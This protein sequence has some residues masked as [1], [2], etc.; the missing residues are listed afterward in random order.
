MN[1][2]VG[3]SLQIIGKKP[4]PK[5]K[6]EHSRRY[7]KKRT[8]LRRKHIADLREVPIADCAVKIHINHDLREVLFILSARYGGISDE[9]AEIK[10]RSSRHRGV[11]IQ[12][13]H[14]GVSR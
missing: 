10:Q 7:R 3:V 12:E 4:N 5:N 2:E 14:G 11:E 9:I 8:L 13:T 6:G 1:T